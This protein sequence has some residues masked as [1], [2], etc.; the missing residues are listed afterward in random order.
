MLTNLLFDFKPSNDNKSV[1]AMQIL[2]FSL[3]SNNGHFYPPE[4][5]HEPSTSPPPRPQYNIL[6]TSASCELLCTLYLIHGV[7][8]LHWA[9]PKKL[10]YGKPRLGESTLTK[11]DLDTP[12]L[13]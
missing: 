1:L 7:F 8:F 10:K 12:N 4:P 5:F 3:A 6:P 9:F 13:A 11:I 2:I